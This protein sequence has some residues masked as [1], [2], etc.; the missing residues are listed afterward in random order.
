MKEHFKDVHDGKN[1]IKMEEPFNCKICESTFDNKPKLYEHIRE[2]HQD[3]IASGKFSNF[4]KDHTIKEPLKCN[5]CGFTFEIKSQLYGHITSMHDDKKPFK[6]NS[7]N[8][9][10]SKK[11]NLDEHIYQFHRDTQP[12]FKCE[13][14]QTIFSKISD[15]EVHISMVH[16]EKKPYRCGMCGV[17]YAEKHP[18]H[19]HMVVIHKAKSTSKCRICH[20]LFNDVEDLKNHI[21]LGHEV[22]DH[23]GKIPIAPKILKRK[24]SNQ[25][26]DAENP[27]QCNKCGE[28]FKS[29]ERLI[30]H[31]TL[32]HDEKK[33]FGIDDSCISESGINESFNDENKT[34]I[35]SEE[36]IISGDEINSEDEI[37]SE[38]YEDS[39]GEI[40]PP[41]LKKSSKGNVSFVHEEKKFKHKC[42]KCQHSFKLKV[43]LKKHMKIV[44]E[45]KKPFDCSFCGKGFISKP[46]LKG[47]I[48]MAHDGE[49][50]IES[51]EENVEWVGHEMP[52]K[53]KFCDKRFLST[54][55]MLGH[56]ASA[57][58]GKKRQNPIQSVHDGKKPFSCKKCR[59]S[60]KSE[61][62]LT[63]HITLIHE[64][65]KPFGVNDSFR[66]VG[67]NNLDKDENMSSCESDNDDF[68]EGVAD[69]LIEE[70]LASPVSKKSSK[71]KQGQKKFKNQCEECEQSFKFKSGLKK[72]MKIAHE[73]NKPYKCGFC[74]KRFRSK[75]GLQGHINKFHEGRD[76]F[77]CTLCESGFIT[78]RSLKYHTSQCTSV[79]EEKNQEAQEAKDPLEIDQEVEEIANDQSE[80]EEPIKSENLNQNNYWMKRMAKIHGR[81]K[82]SVSS[83]SEDS[84]INMDSEDLDQKK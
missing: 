39:D 22:T 42:E 73:E 2:E 13:V 83:S 43:G 10:Y 33:P 16:E 45:K 50:P 5:I 19:R 38:H 3:D 53:C 59:Q 8:A 55:G 1:P 36:E 78:I 57:H 26:S 11:Q 30:A 64:E 6:C 32:V 56:L 44:H 29:G 81:K 9:K 23:E 54:P 40:D 20:A 25:N 24:I 46:G 84:G 61:Q 34:K 66:D 21:V 17:K 69:K 18:L 60:F 51:I 74:I 58:K 72:H 28:D 67:E 68:L 48:A 77:Q 41:T 71:G 75:G 70:S 37:M 14:C 76:P 47:H 63:A 27:F 31:V 80:N 65:K 79:H 49:N 35:I 15:L 52:Y 82:A 12:D 7:C 4:Q 62:R